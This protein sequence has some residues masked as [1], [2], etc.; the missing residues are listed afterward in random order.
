MPIIHMICMCTL[1]YS[2]YQVIEGGDAIVKTVSNTVGK[3]YNTVC[4]DLFSEATFVQNTGY[5][6]AQ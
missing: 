5:A 6:K 1:C 2:N 4:L 3:E